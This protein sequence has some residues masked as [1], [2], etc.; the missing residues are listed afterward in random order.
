MLHANQIIHESETQRQFVRLQLPATAKIGD[1]RL[2]VKDLS[3]GGLALRDVG[4]AFKKGQ[5]LDMTLILPFAEF[6]LDIDLK[7]EIQYIDKKTDTA[8]CRFT[9]LTQNQTSIL[10]HVVRSFVAGDVVGADNILHV[11]SRENFVNI[12]KHNEDHTPT[13]TEQIKTYVIYGLIASAIIALSSFIIG[14]IMEKMFVVKTSTAQVYVE[15]INITA[16]ASGLYMPALPEG[17]KMTK[18]GQL[19]ARIQHPKTKE[20]TNITS[21]CDCYIAQENILPDQYISQDSP[22]FNLIPKNQQAFIKADIEMKNVHKLDIG[23]KALADISG[24]KKPIKGQIS[25][26]IVNQNALSLSTAPTATIYITPEEKISVGMMGRP[27]FV[28]FHL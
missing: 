18:T 4:K 5:I 23:T 16:S 22:L 9:D 12:R 10:N 13:P 3:S 6:S 24:I 26:I 17:V 14:N 21:P 20:F 2:T 19:I 1:N 27:A 11:V 7:I 28:E 8:G 25:N 15:T